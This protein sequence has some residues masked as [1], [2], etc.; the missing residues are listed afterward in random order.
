MPRYRI[1]AFPTRDTD[2][3]DYRLADELA[4]APVTLDGRPAMIAGRLNRFATV[5]ALDG[6]ARA[7]WT[8]RA[9]GRIVA[10]G[11]AFRS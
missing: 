7:D 8:W 1:P 10:A 5:I 11:G 4:G 2:P 9:A 3:A 6:G